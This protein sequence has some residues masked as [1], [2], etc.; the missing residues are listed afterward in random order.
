VDQGA[1][2]ESKIGDGR[3]LVER[4]AADGNPVRAAFWARTVE[5]DL[6]FL[7]VVSDVYD[8]DGPTASY[9][10]VHSAIQKLGKC[11][12]RSSEIKVISPKNPMAKDVLAIMA[13]HP[14]RLGA[15]PWGALGSIAVEQTYIYPPQVFTFTHENP[16]TTDDIGREILR[17]MNRGP[18]LDQPS[19]VTL[20]DGS[21]FN[22][23]PF[24]LELGTQR[25]L[26]ARFIADGEAAPR[27][28]RLDE[29]A[30][31]S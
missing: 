17:L 1:L 24:S 10:A 23:V 11:S 4:F 16:M 27:G 8:R 14:G 6:S 12:V 9:R 3:R 2:V 31:I 5:D 18:G 19:H 20:K 7:Y 26:M 30:S 28:V 13:H 21:A 29:I 25:A 22:G 15:E